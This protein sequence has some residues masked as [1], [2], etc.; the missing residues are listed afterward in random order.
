MLTLEVDNLRI[1]ILCK[2]FI[3]TVILINLSK[4]DNSKT[5]DNYS[6]R[7][8]LFKLTFPHLANAGTQIAN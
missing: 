2:H 6:L 8:S 3:D 4:N 1:Q 5:S 7:K